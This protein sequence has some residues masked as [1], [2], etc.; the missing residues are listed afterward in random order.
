MVVATVD[1]A[2]AFETIKHES[3]WIALAQ[4]G[5]VPRYFSLLK[6]L[7]ADKRATVLTDKVSDGFEMKRAR[8]KVSR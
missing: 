1:F 3:L 4:F 8:S 6:R 5:F 2:K 7:C